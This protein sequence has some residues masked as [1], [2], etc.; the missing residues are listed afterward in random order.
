MQN[1]TTH[2]KKI[3]KIKVNESTNRPYWLEFAKKK[4]K[5]RQNFTKKKQ[6]QV[7]RKKESLGKSKHRMRICLIPPM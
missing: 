4:K 3:I 6:I 1:Y 5:K 2:V 7:E